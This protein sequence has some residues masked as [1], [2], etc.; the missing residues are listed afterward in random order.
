M[1][2]FSGSYGFVF[3]LD[4]F[5]EEKAKAMSR[6][7][8]NNPRTFA[9]EPLTY[10]EF[11]PEAMHLTLFHAKIK[12]APVEAVQEILEA[13]SIHVQGNVIFH[14]VAT[15]SDKFL[16]WDADCSALLRSAHLSALHLSDFLDVEAKAH[17]EDEEALK[18]SAE[19]RE[20]LK[21]YGHPLMRR[22]Y[23]PHITLAYNS[24]GFPGHRAIG[25]L[26]HVGRIRRVAFAEIG[27]Y[28]RVQNIIF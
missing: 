19:E 4:S 12:G 17:A 2:T 21:R 7:E 23:R 28:G 16:F 5:T 11:A 18:L 24:S 14:R 27:S 15:F 8:L 22:L 1:N 26:N 25:E 3:L 20:S 13:L 9:G 6:M 10:A